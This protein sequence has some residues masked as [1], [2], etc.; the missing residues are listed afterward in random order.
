M[1]LDYETNIIT[2]ST[3]SGCDVL[4]LPGLLPIFLHGCE[5]KS[6][7]GLGTRLQ[8]HIYELLASSTAK[9]TGNIE[10][11]RNVDSVS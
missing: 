1:S 8:N 5:I 3:I 2:E 11:P 9:L 4:L 10:V 7:W 6:G